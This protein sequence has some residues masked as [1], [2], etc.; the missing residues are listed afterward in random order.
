MMLSTVISC[1]AVLGIGIAM[2]DSTKGFNQ[3]YNR[4]YSDVVAESHSAKK[5]FDS[6]VRRSNCYKALLDDDELGV[7]VQYYSGPSAAFPDLYTYFYYEDTHLYAE[8]GRLV[9]G[10]KEILDSRAVCGN[11]QSCLF[12]QTGRSLQM[13]LTLSDG[14]HQITTVTSAVMHN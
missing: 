8:Y 13:V 9:G 3:L 11:V 4:V 2:S 5:M 6:M 1:I 12:K 14:S 10:A 7:E